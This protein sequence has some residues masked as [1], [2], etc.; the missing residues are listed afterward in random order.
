MFT[1]YGK[2][3]SPYCD[4]CLETRGGGLTIWEFLAAPTILYVRVAAEHYFMQ[5]M[6]PGTVVLTCKPCLAFLRTPSG[7]FRAGVPGR[8]V[9][10][11]FWRASRRIVMAVFSMN[12]GRRH[13]VE[14]GGSP[15]VRLSE[16]RLCEGGR[17]LKPAL[18]LKRPFGVGMSLRC[19]GRKDGPKA[20]RA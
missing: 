15:R 3:W 7:S 17:G 11:R 10:S 4:R 13:G 16:R 6:V 19:S 20:A 5:G 1:R 9:P 14:V 8:M 2:S 12:P 18:R